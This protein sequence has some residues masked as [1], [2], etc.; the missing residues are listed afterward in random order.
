M[1]LKFD[2][3]QTIR[4]IHFPSHGDPTYIT[5]FALISFDYAQETHGPDPLSGYDPSTIYVYPPADW[6]GDGGF[7]LT[8]GIDYWEN[9]YGFSTGTKFSSFSVYDQI[10]RLVGDF[11]DGEV[12]PVMPAIPTVVSPGARTYITTPGLTPTFMSWVPVGS[13]DVDPLFPDFGNGSAILSFDQA[14][15][16][17]PP[18]RYRTFGGFFTEHH[19]TDYVLY[20]APSTFSAFE[21]A[22]LSVVYEGESFTRI[23]VRLSEGTG[24]NQ[25]TDYMRVAAVFK[26]LS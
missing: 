13:G 26:K 6:V 24:T 1:A 16:A 25:F 21:C 23:G 2:H 22:P 14:Q 7:T 9:L 18:E 10:G 20:E 4:A 15:V 8:V 12:T 17:G 11:S 19:W 5:T 3:Y